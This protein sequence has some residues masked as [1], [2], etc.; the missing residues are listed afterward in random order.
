M[1]AL[2]A[3]DLTS[4]DGFAIQAYKPGQSVRTHA[5]VTLDSVLTDPTSPTVAVFLPGGVALS[6]APIPAKDST[7]L[8]H[9]DYVVPS[10]AITGLGV[11]RWT[12]TGNSP[13]QCA[14]AEKRFVVSSLDATS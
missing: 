1:S 8:W 10:S 5:T 7:G 3:I 6:P 12:S 13:A 14:V 9:V 11:E 2:L 4:I